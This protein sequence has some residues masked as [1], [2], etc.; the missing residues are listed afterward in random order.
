MSDYAEMCEE[1]CLGLPYLDCYAEN[2]C[3]SF[4]DHA[5]FVRALVATG[6]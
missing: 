6:R 3:Y 5:S 1:P 2:C 4:P